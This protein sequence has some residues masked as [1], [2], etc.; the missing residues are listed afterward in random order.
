MAGVEVEEEVEEE[1]L[2]ADG[3]DGARELSGCCCP[4][5]VVAAAAAVAAAEEAGVA[6]DPAAGVAGAACTG[7]L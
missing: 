3:V 4:A 1:E 6:V 7:R 2:G 5:A